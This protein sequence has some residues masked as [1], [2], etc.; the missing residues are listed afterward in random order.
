MTKTPGQVAYEAH[1][2]HAVPWDVTTFERRH[3]EAVA[4]AVIAAARSKIEAEARAAMVEL[5]I[6]TIKR[7]MGDLEPGQENHLRALAAM[8][9]THVCVPVEPTQEQYDAVW[10][11]LQQDHF[12]RVRQVL[13]FDE[14][15]KLYQEFHKGMLAA[16]EG[17]K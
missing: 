15:R 6:T 13:S 11:G 7:D 5:V 12:K 8:P 1:A 4:A 3:W 2:N 14:L 10:K 17:D 9:P 16:S